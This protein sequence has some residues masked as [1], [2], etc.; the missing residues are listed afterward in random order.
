M[1][2]S[3]SAE[4]YKSLDH[5]QLSFTGFNVLVG[6]N[7][8]GKSTVLQAIDFLMRSASEDFPSI[9]GHRGLS[10][11][12]IVS[13]LTPRRQ[14]RF[15]SEYA[16]PVGERT[17]HL[18][19]EMVMDALI[20]DNVIKLSSEKIADLDKSI[21]LLS[22]ESGK[23]LKVADG[24]KTGRVYPQL[25]LES[26]A[27][28][29]AVDVQSEKSL[30][31]LVA[32][33]R[34]LMSSCSYDMLSP[35]EMRQSSRGRTS[36]IGTS[37]RDLAAFIKSM[38]KEQKDS[39]MKTLHSLMGQHVPEE[40]EAHTKGKPGW[41][42]IESVERYGN[43]KVRI[44]SK[45]MSDGMLRLLAFIAINETEAE[46]SLILLDEIENGINSNYAEQLI[47]IMKQS[48]EKKHRQMIVTTH[49]TAFL[50]YV[51]AEDIIYL[52]RD[53]KTGFSGAVKMLDIAGM[54]EKT[55]YMYP[56]EVFMNLSNREIME[57]IMK[58]EGSYEGN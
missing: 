1:I 17:C 49:S 36:S 30:P 6:N 28:K 27:M 31:E 5:L 24:S 3:F 20:K 50:D 43:K 54:K 9:I 40:V 23:E 21:V 4:N 35:S 56:G 12:D 42:T 46:T 8:S 29:V 33:K 10:V 2:T 25:A 22:Y 32:L 44:S 16:V 38:S 14:I 13:K 34:F 45:G 7:A 18:R 58:S 47:S 11:S 19:W 26:S 39:F 37:G 57:Q 52:Y 51:S 55:E 53:E 48:Y 41:T 15:T